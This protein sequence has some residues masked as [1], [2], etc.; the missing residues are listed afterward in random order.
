ML[1]KKRKAIRSIPYGKYTA[2]TK[3]VLLMCQEV[4]KMKTYISQDV[5]FY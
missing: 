2:A 1:I 3:I 4:Q 5:E